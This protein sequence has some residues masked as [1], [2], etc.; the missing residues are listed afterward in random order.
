[1]SYQLFVEMM[2]DKGISFIRGE[3]GKEAV[4]K[5]KTTPEVDLILMDIKMPLMNGYDATRQIKA[6]YPHIPIIAQTAFASKMDMDKTLKA[7]CDAYLS[8]PIQKEDFIRVVNR[9]LKEKRQR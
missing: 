2:A 8:K 3:N 1:M 6:G 9:L 5:M 7:G 4:E